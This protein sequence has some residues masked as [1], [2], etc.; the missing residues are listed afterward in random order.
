MGDEKNA[1]GA[2]GPRQFFM[3]Q[4][5]KPRQT[6]ANPGEP[7]RTPA[8]PCSPMR[9]VLAPV[10]EESRRRFPDSGL[11]EVTLWCCGTSPKNLIL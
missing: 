6:P 10:K 5:Q 3:R 9:L 1:G 2:F 8:N 7:R 11:F 4:G